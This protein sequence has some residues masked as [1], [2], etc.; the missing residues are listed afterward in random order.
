MNFSGIIDKGNSKRGFTSE[1]YAKTIDTELI[2]P[3]DLTFFNINPRTFFIAPSNRITLNKKSFRSGIR[4]GKYKTAGHT[5]SN[6][7]EFSRT[8][9]FSESG[10]LNQI[11]FKKLT[12][13]DKEEINIRID[14]NK[15]IAILPQS[16]KAKIAHQKAIRH[17]DRGK[18]ARVTKNYIYKELQSEKRS[19]L[20]EKFIKYEL[21]INIDVRY[22]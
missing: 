17:A 5:P 10:A 20:S 16:V 11:H 7:F 22:K 15:E 9:R 19:I 21:R 3:I 18:I 2:N 1:K 14:K 6:S 13:K 4:T 8:P 12:E